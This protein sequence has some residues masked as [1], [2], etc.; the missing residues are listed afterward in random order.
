[1]ITYSNSTLVSVKIPSPN[2]NKSRIHSIYNPTGVID[3]IAIHHMAG[4]LSVEACGNL[5]KSTAKATSSTYGIGSDGRIGQYADE[6]Y[7]PWTTSSREIDYRAITIEVANDGGEPNWH[8]SDAALASLIKLCAD[9]CKR[10]NIKEVIFTGDIKGT[11]IMHKW[12]VPTSCPGPYLASKFPYIAAEVN[13]LIGVANSEP[14]KPSTPA[15]PAAKPTSSIDEGSLVTITSGSKYYNGGSIPSWVLN[16]KWYVASV[17]GD[18][19][20]LGKNASGTNNIQS[21]INV[22]YLKV[23]SASSNSN[24]STPKPAKIKEGDVVKMAANA[25]V[26]GTSKKFQS[27]VY[28]SKLYVRELDGNRA[29]ISTQKTGAITGAVDVK[30][31][32][33]Q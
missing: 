24:P 4:N 5:F 8:I 16:D 15:K 31:L 7:R 3:K 23:V 9:V 11:L 14:V 10:N 17:S 33:K 13:K 6:S 30:Y 32:T 28:S 29:V 2:V 19:A 25:P 1:M 20:V 21:P 27:W 18:R 26:Y 22:K 12:I